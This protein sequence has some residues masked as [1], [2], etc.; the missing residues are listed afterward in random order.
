M[1]VNAVSTNPNKEVWLKSAWEGT[2]ENGVWKPKALH[3]GDEAGFLRSDDP[4]YR[5]S[6]YRVSPTEPAIFH[7]KAVVYDK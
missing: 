6:A 4:T 2:Y 5:I 3:N 7:F 1:R